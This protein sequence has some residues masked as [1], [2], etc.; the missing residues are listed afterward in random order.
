MNYLMKLWTLTNKNF[1]ALLMNMNVLEVCNDEDFLHSLQ[2]RVATE[3]LQNFWGRAKDN[4]LQ[5]TQNC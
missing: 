4:K 3:I 1:Y 2:V 5:D